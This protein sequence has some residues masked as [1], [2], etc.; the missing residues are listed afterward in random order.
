MFLQEFRRGK[1]KAE[2]SYICFDA[3]SKLMAA[4]SDRGTIHIWSMGSC[5]KTMNEKPIQKDSSLVDN[6]ITGRSEIDSRDSN[7]TDVTVN[8]GNKKE[9]VEDFPKNQSSI[10]KGLPGIGTF[11]KSEWSFAK[12][13]ID[14]QKS[15]CAFGEDNTI[16][17]ITSE[18][19]YYQA[20]IDLKKG[21]DCVITKEASLNGTNK[22]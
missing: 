7:T 12:L 19:K 15:I 11:F 9:K 10:F 2:I 6:R 4:T 3:A 8:E 21:G 22:K 1:E 20:T 18:G 16:I 5:I 17:A 13:R 14:N